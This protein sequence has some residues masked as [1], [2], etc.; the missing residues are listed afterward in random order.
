MREEASRGYF[1]LFFSFLDDLVDPLYLLLGFPGRQAS[2]HSGLG[3][4]FRARCTLVH[5]FRWMNQR[6]ICTEKCG[7]DVRGLLGTRG[8]LEEGGMVERKAGGRSPSLVELIF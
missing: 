5:T 3:S 6:T 1:F 2:T 4:P 8:G 7:A